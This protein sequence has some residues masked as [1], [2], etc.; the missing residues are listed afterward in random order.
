MF[1][2]NQSP[3]ILYIVHKLLPILILLI[4]LLTGFGAGGVPILKKL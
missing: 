4:E 1:I 3:I 2:E